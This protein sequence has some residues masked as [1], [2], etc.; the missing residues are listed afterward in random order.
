MLSDISPQLAPNSPAFFNF[1]EGEAKAEKTFF[2][3]SV[4][5]IS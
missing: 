1:S 3:K 4:L 2:E 5:I